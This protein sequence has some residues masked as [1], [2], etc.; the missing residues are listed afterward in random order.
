MDLKLL[1]SNRYTFAQTLDT[2]NNAY[3]GEGVKVM[4]HD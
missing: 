4:T 3:K 1:I 2:F